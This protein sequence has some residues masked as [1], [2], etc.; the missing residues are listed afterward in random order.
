M[1]HLFFFL[2]LGLNLVFPN[3]IV[4]STH[5]ALGKAVCPLNINHFR[6][7]II[8]SSQPLQLLSEAAE[9][10][11]VL[12]GIRLL[13]SQYLRVSGNF[14]LPPD[15]AEVCWDLFGNLFDEFMPR[16]RIEST[17]GFKRSL[18]SQVCNNIKNSSQFE[19]LLSP[20]ELNQIRGSCYKSL[21]NTSLCHLC[22]DPLLS[23]NKAY[24]NVPDG[25]NVTDCEGYP[26]IYAA[27]F[28]NRFGPTD[29]GTAKCLFL[30][31]FSRTSARSEP[32]KAVILGVLVGCLH[33]FVGAVLVVWCVWM[34]HSRRTKRKRTNLT[35]LG[36][37]SLP[38]MEMVDGNTALRRFTLDE[39]KRATR[40]FSR[41]N[42]IGMGGYGNVYKGILEDGS[43]VA[44]KRFKNCSAAG[45]EAFVHE[46][47]VI[48]SVK[49]VN[50]LALRGYCTVT[51]PFEA[52]QRIIVCDLMRNGSLY[53]HL[54]GSGM[55]K[56]SWP[57]RQ[58]ITLGMA[59]GL[60]YLH[61]GVQPAIIHRDIKASNILVD[62]TFEPKLADF[63]LAKFTA[64]GLTHLSTRVAGTLGYVAPEYA[65]Y[66]QLS[67]RSDVYSFGV[68]LLEILSGKK[69]IIPND[70]SYETLLLTDWAWSLVR[71][72]RLLDVIE[73]A[74]PELGAKDE[75]EKYVLVAILCSH[76]VA[77][78]RPTMD[79]LVK[80]LE[81]DCPVPSIP[82]RPFPLLA[83]FDDK[84][85]SMSIT[86][87]RDTPKSAE[88][89]TLVHKSDHP[90]QNDGDKGVISES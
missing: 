71:E 13:R 31:D 84:E 47:E 14:T 85:M 41:D 17:C 35:Q 28:A 6:K 51:G 3:S 72:G 81:N 5:E 33:G 36:T 64:E 29:L 80:I 12:Q 90:V 4:S 43:E 87:L 19:R 75:I 73:E 57:I 55:K 8:Q 9:C 44:F 25:G 68:V 38:G 60:A 88:Q 23:I 2:F 39:I 42:I 74:M 10:Q 11:Y 69:A 53:D 59:R 24:F 54:F 46:V 22:V 7:L 1:S 82:D 63:G 50:L 20:N 48:A 86:G 56:L 34:W 76:P 62:E 21:G 49:H 30:L 40:N 79:Q 15:V 89:H 32:H 27:A 58:K 61:H 78:A 83:H 77:Y 37:T 70:H 66:G 65:L 18:L 52:H 45:E 67:E 16:L 26:F